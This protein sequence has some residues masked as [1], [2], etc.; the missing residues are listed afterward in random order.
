MKRSIFTYKI[1]QLKLKRKVFRTLK[2]LAKALDERDIIAV[3]FHYWIIYTR[4]IFN[5]VLN[6][7]YRPLAKLYLVN[8]L[9]RIN[10]FR[11]T[12]DRNSITDGLTVLP[13]KSTSNIT[14]FK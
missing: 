10:S 7:S 3:L 6:F 9:N 4:H 1:V 13:V 8:F 14:E 12:A 2:I 11:Y 5:K